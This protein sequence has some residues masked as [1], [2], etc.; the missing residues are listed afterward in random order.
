MSMQAVMAITGIKSKSE[1]IETVKYH[2]L[3]FATFLPDS[4]PMMNEEKK[5]FIKRYFEIHL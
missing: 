2:Q 3:S 1:F 5:E 4:R